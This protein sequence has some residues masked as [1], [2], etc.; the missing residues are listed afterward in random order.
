MFT[1]TPFWKGLVLASP[2]HRSQDPSW[3]FLWQSQVDGRVGDGGAGGICVPRCA[4][5]EGRSVQVV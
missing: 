5:R 2:V 1:F 4:D 3:I